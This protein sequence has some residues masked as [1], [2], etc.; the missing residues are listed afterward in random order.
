MKE[1][2]GLRS[3]MYAI[4]SNNKKITKKGKGV[5]KNVLNKKI[6]FEDY[7]RCVNEHCNLIKEQVTIKSFLH[8]VYTV[9]NSKIVL[10]PAD[11]KRFCIPNEHNTLAWGH[12]NI[13]S[14]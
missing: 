2:I 11:Q 13:D 3:K 9:K 1:F 5:K 10:D 6:T 4:K 12:Y 7:E 8:N 14:F